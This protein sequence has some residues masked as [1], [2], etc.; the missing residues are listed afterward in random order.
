MRNILLF[1]GN[2]YHI[3][4]MSNDGS[5]KLHKEYNETSFYIHWVYRRPRQQKGDS[6]AVRALDNPKSMYI[7]DRRI[8]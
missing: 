2:E 6:S 8:D 3:C 4:Q 1:R 7:N 5:L